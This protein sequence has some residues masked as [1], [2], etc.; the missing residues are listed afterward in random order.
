MTPPAFLAGDGSLAKRTAT[1]GG[2]TVR[3]AAQE[4]E[5]TDGNHQETDGILGIAIG[6]ATAEET[7]KT[8][9]QG[10]F[11]APC[12][13]LRPGMSPGLW[14][15]SM[16]CDQFLWEQ[17]LMGADTVSPMQLMQTAPHPAGNL[18]STPV[19]PPYGGLVPEFAAQHA[20]CVLPPA[21]AGVKEAL[22]VKAQRGGPQ[23]LCEREINRCGTPMPVSTS[24]CVARPPERNNVSALPRH[25]RAA[26]PRTSVRPSR[27]FGGGPLDTKAAQLR[28]FRCWG[29]PRGR[30]GSKTANAQVPAPPVSRPHPSRQAGTVYVPLHGRAPTWV[31]DRAWRATSQPSA[32]SSPPVPHPQPQLAAATWT[33]RKGPIHLG[34][35][36]SALGPERKAGPNW[37]VYATRAQGQVAAGRACWDVQPAP[38]G[39]QASARSVCYGGCSGARSV[40]GNGGQMFRSTECCWEWWTVLVGE[41]AVAGAAGCPV[42][43][44]PG[45]RVSTSWPSPVAAAAPCCQPGGPAPGLPGMESRDGAQGWSAG[46]PCE[47]SLFDYL[48]AAGAYRTRR[49]QVGPS[50]GRGTSG[51]RGWGGASPS[52][53]LTGFTPVRGEPGPALG[54]LVAP[55]PSRGRDSEGPDPFGHQFLSAGP[56]GSVPG[57]RAHR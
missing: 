57:T 11:A 52:R 24:A 32:A 17:I 45:A 35:S 51:G 38:L 5:Q 30:E 46:R 3:T 48:T 36:F 43:P 53:A 33:L 25:A 8:T 56:Q 31:A 37:S 47:S 44:G 7:T 10:R 18:L 41:K 15:A 1:P 55:T 22:H 23:A 50:G 14:E 39:Q 40:V 27:R 42:R 20:A 29:R 6:T 26:H 16:G 19:R 9:A 21:H 4:F 2:T 54:R 13:T 12:C 49:R 28:S 34:I